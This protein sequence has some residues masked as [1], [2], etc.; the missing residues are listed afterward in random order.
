MGGGGFGDAAQQMENVEAVLGKVV[1]EG[2]DLIVAVGG[3]GLFDGVVEK[4]LYEGAVGGGGI[5]G[6]VGERVHP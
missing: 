4:L 5:G 6:I 3:D 2:I 1:A